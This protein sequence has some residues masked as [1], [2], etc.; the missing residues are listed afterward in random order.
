VILVV[1]WLEKTL[2]YLGFS[3]NEADEEDDDVQSS[4]QTLDGPTRK[5]TPVLSLH[6]APEV[7]IAVTSPTS[8]G[9]AEKLAA[10]LKSRRP[11]IVNFEG[12]SKDVAQRIIDFLSGTVYAL[13]G[14]TCKVAAET[15]LFNPSNTSVYTEEI[16]DLRERLALRWDQGTVKDLFQEKG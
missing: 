7:K 5:R 14:S 9:E 13:N 2:G 3:E 15:F 8:F 16:A 4:T 12:T 6:S 11:V 1:G 10:H